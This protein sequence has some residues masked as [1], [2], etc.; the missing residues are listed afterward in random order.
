MNLGRPLR[1]SGDCEEQPVQAKFS[2]PSQMVQIGNR[3]LVDQMG[4]LL[5]ADGSE[6]AQEHIPAGDHV[7]EQL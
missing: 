7:V 1:Q 3:Q 2:E 6:L 5:A 4:L